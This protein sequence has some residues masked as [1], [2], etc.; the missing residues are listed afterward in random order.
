[1]GS[2]YITRKIP[3]LARRMLS[4]KG[5]KVVVNG[6]AKNLTKQQLIDVFGEYDGVLTMMTDKISEEIIAASSGKLKII[7]NYAVGVDNI[8]VMSAKHRGIAVTNTPAVAGESVA[9]H[10]FALILALK[11][12][13]LEADRFVRLG[14]YGQWDPMMFLSNQLWGMTIGIIGLGRIGT[15]VGY[16]AA[17]GYKM[18]ILY[19]DIVR[20]EDFEMLT[21]ARAVTFTHL[22]KETDVVTLHVP[23]T[24]ATVH[25]IGKKELKLMK[26]TA[27]LINTSRGAIVDEKALVWALEND[28]I[29]AAGLDVFEREPLVSREL[30]T[31]SKVILTPHIASATFETR[32]AMARIAAQ[33]IIDVFEGKTPLGLVKVD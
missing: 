15:H 14:K 8:D 3:D 24:L 26:N 30:V 12:R 2:I 27:I 22:L 17:N 13:L 20:S 31:S 16:I 29:A 21:E 18:K 23:L 6:Q 7:S 4:K 32:E 28:E 10:T 19:H 25:L 33:N 9:E 11:K 5:F 1:M